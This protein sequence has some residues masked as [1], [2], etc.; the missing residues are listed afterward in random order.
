ME[1]KIYL[2]FRRKRFSGNSSL[3]GSFQFRV[4]ITKVKLIIN[5]TL[6]I[7]GLAE[8]GRVFTETENSNI[9]HS[10]FGGGI[11][12]SYLDRTF[13]IVSTVAKSNESLLF[14]FGFSSFF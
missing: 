12:I 14:Y 10:N 6:G 4:P 3:L 11:W 1:L 2:G 9:W 5:G 7:H 13:N 8:S